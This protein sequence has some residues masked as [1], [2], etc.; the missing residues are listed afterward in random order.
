V[1]NLPCQSTPLSSETKSLDIYSVHRFRNQSMRGDTRRRPSDHAA[2]CRRCPGK[3]SHDVHTHTCLPDLFVA[4]IFISSPPSQAATELS[5]RHCC[6]ASFAIAELANHRKNAN[7]IFTIASP[8][9]PLP[10]PP[11]SCAI[12][13][14]VR[15]Q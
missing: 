14:L 2:T 13:A 7:S 8:C 5:A 15:S 11:P 6:R 3:A 10:S 1:L 9:P 12:R 4:Q